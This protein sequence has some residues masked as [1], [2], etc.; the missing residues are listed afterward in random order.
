MGVSRVK[1]VGQGGSQVRV[2][3]DRVSLSASAQGI[4]T[5]VGPF[6][7][8][9]NSVAPQTQV[10]TAA[11][12]GL[13]S[14]DIVTG[15]GLRLAVA[16]GGTNPTTARFGIADSTGKILAISAN[17]NASA[18]WAATGAAPFPLASP[19]T[20]VADGAYYACFVVNGTWGTTQPTLAYGS[21]ATVAAGA[22]ASGVTAFGAQISQTDLPAVGSSFTLTASSGRGY[23]MAFY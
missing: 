7:S 15:V 1:L 23:Y 11:L 4:I 17:L 20:V 2:E 12:M 14:G 13:R 3:N 5:E 10:L 21:G 8:Y 22:F 6:S 16:A 18:V 19:Y 9:P